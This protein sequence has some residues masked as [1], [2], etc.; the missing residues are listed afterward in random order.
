[1][2]EQG[3]GMEYGKGHTPNS[4][5]IKEGVSSHIVLVLGV[6]RSET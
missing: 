2:C 6:R 5:V 4:G 3:Q 1:M